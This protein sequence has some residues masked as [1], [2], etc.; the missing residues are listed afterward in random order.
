ME[1][2]NESTDLLLSK[3]IE[4]RSP[5]IPYLEEVDMVE[6]QHFLAGWWGKQRPLTAA[7]ITH[8]YSN[9]QTNYMGTAAITGFGQVTKNEEVKA[10]FKRGKEIS[11]KQIEI[12]TEY[13]LKNDLPAPTT[14]DAEVQVTTDPPFS[15]KLMLFQISMMS[16]AGM[17]NYGTA[18]SASP[19]RDI[20]SDYVR[21]LG[22]IGLYAEDGINLQIKYE[23]LERPPHAAN[24]DQLMK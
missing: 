8:L 3:G 2:F 1:L 16:A 6:K 23:W 19:R 5:Y 13:L 14:W 4:V 20:A 12:F 18:I 10:Y 15:D 22:E 9:I 17:G 11:K 24:R 7:E 21:L